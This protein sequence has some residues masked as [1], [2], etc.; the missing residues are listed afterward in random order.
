MLPRRLLSMEPGP[1]LAGLLASVDRSRVGAEDLHHL[2]AARARQVAHEQAELLADLF[3]AGLS[4]HE[5]GDS[6][7]RAKDADEFAPDQIAWTLRCSRSY[8]QAQVHLGGALTRRLPMVLAA[9]RAGRLD[10]QKANAFVDALSELDEATARQIA[11]RLLDRAREW[12]LPQLRERL[13]YHRMRADPTQVRKR[14][15]R[16]VSDRQVWWHMPEGDGTAFL[17]GANLPPTTAAA[18]YDHVDRLARAA[19]S[20][21]DERTLP[22]LRAD[23]YLALLTGIA[24]RRKPPTDPLT[25]ATD[26]A[27]RASGEVVDDPDDVA[28]RIGRPGSRRAKTARRGSRF[29]HGSG[30]GC[31]AGS[32]S[33]SDEAEA[34]IGIGTFGEVD[35]VTGSTVDAVVDSLVDSPVESTVDSTVNSTVDAVVGAAA[36]TPRGSPAAEKLDMLPGMAAVGDADRCQCGGVRPSDR[37]GVVDIQV[38][39]TTLMCLDDDPALIPG[40]GP[41]IADIARQVAHDQA[42]NPLWRYSITNDEGGL[43]HHG[44]TKRRPNSTEKA[45]VK[46]R[47]RMCRAPGCRQLAMHCDDDHRQEHARKGPSHRGNLCCLCR[48]HH[49]L[50]H[51]RGYVMEQIDVSTS[52]WRAPNGLMYLKGPDDLLNL[53][54]DLDNIDYDPPPDPEPP[55][56]E[57][58]DNGPPDPDQDYLSYAD[59][60]ELTGASR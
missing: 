48:H 39:L 60:E 54:A 27:T 53:T 20:A 41:V 36:P 28:G 35:A 13:R 55:D 25:A 50:R 34:P 40:W 56:K 5:E 15:L 17:G 11:D 37:R 3:E 44:H 14:Y 46:A 18:A 22:Q 21:G 52:W 1:E 8:A 49:R 23:A 51:E 26:A 19:R 6:T 9:L 7:A 59:I 4:A 42:T 47:D 33:G 45:Y 58:P 43:F 32:G 10:V 24:F 30:S 16:A 29:G 57:P 38:K 31:G 12:T 2:V